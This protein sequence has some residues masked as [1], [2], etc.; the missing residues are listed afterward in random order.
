MSSDFIQAI[1]LILFSACLGLAIW[2]RLYTRYW[3]AAFCLIAHY[4]V[5]YAVVNLQNVG[6]LHSI[7]TMLWGI[8]VRLQLAV[9]LLA[10]LLIGR[11]R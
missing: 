3:L 8:G 6:I 9:V 11:W 2:R 1:N 7:P 5:Y 4:V 10:Y